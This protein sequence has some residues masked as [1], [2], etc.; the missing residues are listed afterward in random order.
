MTEVSLEAIEAQI[1]RGEAIGHVWAAALIA[2]IERLR[3]VIET[4]LQ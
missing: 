1:A 2:E 4:H 3:A